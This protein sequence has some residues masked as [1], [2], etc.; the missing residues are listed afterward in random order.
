MGCVAVLEFRVM[1]VEKS[2]QLFLIAT[3]NLF[4]QQRG[5]I[6]LV[7]ISSYL[8]NR[9]HAISGQL[10]GGKERLYFETA[11]KN[12]LRNY[13]NQARCMNQHRKYT[14]ESLSQSPTALFFQNVFGKLVNFAFIISLN[15]NIFI[16]QKQKSRGFVIRQHQV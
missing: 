2:Q 9:R 13:L 4:L 10:R 5:E 3:E 16:N 6:G 8:L 7:N 12:K 14:V 15:I 11:K 1:Q